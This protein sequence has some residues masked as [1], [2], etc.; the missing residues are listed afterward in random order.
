[1]KKIKLYKRKGF[2]ELIQ[3]DITSFSICREF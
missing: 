3:W 2:I 1:L